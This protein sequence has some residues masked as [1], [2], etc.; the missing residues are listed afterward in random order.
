MFGMINT[1]VPV[2]F[3]AF[4][5]DLNGGIIIPKKCAWNCGNSF[6]RLK[7]KGYPS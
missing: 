4:F 6:R 1:F 3:G 5:A 2:D 7:S